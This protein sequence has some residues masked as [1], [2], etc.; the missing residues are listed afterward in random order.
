MQAPPHTPPRTHHVLGAALDRVDGHVKTT[1]A[2][3]YSAEY[4]YPDL[5]HAAL[6]HATV[7]RG[8]ITAIDTTAAA[9]LPGVRAV[10][11]HLTPR[12]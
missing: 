1:G 6:V 11:T 12:P 5:T 3:R 4:P 7:P 8:R 10:I 2:A 9:A